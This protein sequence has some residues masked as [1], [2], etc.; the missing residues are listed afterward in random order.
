MRLSCTDHGDQHQLTQTTCCIRGVL[1]AALWDNDAWK[2]LSQV[3]RRREKAA[4]HYFLPHLRMIREGK[5]SNVLP[6]HHTVQPIQGSFTWG[7]TSAESCCS[8]Q[9]KTMQSLRTLKNQS[10]KQ[11]IWLTVMEEAVGEKNNQFLANGRHY[12]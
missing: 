8:T 3:L 2:Q 5:H 6:V 1:E 7:H 9:L 4:S 12:F 10:Q 11:E